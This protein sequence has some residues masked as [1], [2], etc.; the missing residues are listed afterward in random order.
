M[1]FELFLKIFLICKLVEQPVLFVN[2]LFA[3]KCQILDDLFDN[4][5][6][7]FTPKNRI[8]PGDASFFIISKVL[9]K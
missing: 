3:V 6:P 4:L 2:I 5:H 1:I 8:L 9:R 7:N